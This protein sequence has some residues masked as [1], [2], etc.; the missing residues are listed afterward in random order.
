M[1]QKKLEKKSPAPKRARGA[2]SSFAKKNYSKK[3]VRSNNRSPQS[4]RRQSKK[5]VPP[6]NNHFNDLSV[7][8]GLKIV[9]IGGCEEVGRNMTIFEYEEDIIILDMGLQFPEED[10]PG[11]DYIIPNVKYLKGKEKKI[12]GVIF[13]HGHL[14]HIGAAPILLEKLGN[15]KII[16]RDLTLALIRHRQEDYKKGSAKRLKTQ[17]IN[18]ITD[19]IKLGKFTVRFFQ[20]EHSVMD[21]VGVIL[22]TPD[23]TV[24]HPGDWTMERNAQGKPTIDYRHLRN[25]P[26]PTVLMLESLGST[27]NTPSANSETVQKNLA[28]IMEKAQGRLIIA[29]FS[30]QIERIKWILETAQSMGKK[31][32]L[33]G[34]SMKMN[35][36]MAQKLGYVKLEKSLLIDVRDVDRL[37]DNK[38]VVICTGA[39]GEENAVLSRIIEKSHRSIKLKKSDTL[40]FSSSIIPGNERTI[41]KVKDNVYRQCDHVYHGEI[42]DVHV[43]GHASRQDIWEMIDSVRPDYFMPVYANHFFLKEAKNLAIDKGFPGGNIFVPDNG[44][45]VQISPPD[46]TRILNKKVPSDYVFVD[47]LGITDM[48]NIVLRDRQ[49]LAEDGMVVVI[50]TVESKSG[51]LVQNPDLISRGFVFLK[52]NKGLMEK[53]RKNVRHMVT[54]SDP[55]TWADTNGIKNEIRDEVG[56][57]LFQE[58]QK[59][60][61]VLPVVIEV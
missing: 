39:Q 12:R 1:N 25:L 33:D 55:L 20:I 14:D 31:V 18:K 47:G 28:G 35:I 10:M 56:K 41:Q 42:M 29:T 45:V 7:F 4:Q 3:P 17:R 60:P 2:S 24:I 21:A 30:S 44:S 51:K 38:V 32:A 23:G 6:K 36:E 37:P 27:R 22:N 52:E 61:M 54:K 16:G 19:V 13:S 48:Q 34:F 46:Y 8:S 59:R 26:R 15:P 53:L 40:I 49:L 9:P 5:R 11:I 43:S 57:F 58:T 50:V